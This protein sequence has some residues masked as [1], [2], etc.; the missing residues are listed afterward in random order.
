MKFG[1]FVNDNSYFFR[2]RKYYENNRYVMNC[3][4]IKLLWYNIGICNFNEYL[5][6]NFGFGYLK[7]S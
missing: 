3:I 5:L 7:K 4:C 1:F 6:I 2:K